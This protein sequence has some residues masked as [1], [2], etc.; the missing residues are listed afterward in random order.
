MLTEQMRI[1]RMTQMIANRNSVSLVPSFKLSLS[2]SPLSLS[3][4]HNY[5]MYLIHIYYVMVDH[6]APVSPFLQ[7]TLE[8]RLFAVTV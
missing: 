2:L 8:A 7:L 1:M 6:I 3:Q 4:L 5:Y